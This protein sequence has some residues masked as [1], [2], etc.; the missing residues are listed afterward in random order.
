MDEAYLARTR[1]MRAILHAL[2]ELVFSKILFQKRTLLP[3]EVL[4]F[5]SQIGHCICLL[6]YRMRFIWY[7]S[8][9]LQYECVI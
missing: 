8:Y 3:K 7:G 1:M 2:Q 9:F 5:I 6:H 4:F